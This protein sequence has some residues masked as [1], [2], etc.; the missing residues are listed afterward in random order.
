MAFL[1]YQSTQ[2]FCNKHISITL[3]AFVFFLCGSIATCFDPAGP[4]SDNHYVN[5]S[6]VIRLFTDIDPDR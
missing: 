4:S 1:M 3:L 2:R 6:L 5:M